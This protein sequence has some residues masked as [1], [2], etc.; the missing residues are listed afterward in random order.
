MQ[1]IFLPMPIVFL[2]SLMNLVQPLIYEGSLADGV[3]FR[4]S[5]ISRFLIRRGSIL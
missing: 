3:S 1:N 5:L 4:V 2:I